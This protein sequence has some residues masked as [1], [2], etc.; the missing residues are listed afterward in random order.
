M[1]RFKA[2]KE[3]AFRIF[4][5]SSLNFFD[6]CLLQKFKELKSLHTFCIDCSKFVV[7]SKF[8][9]LYTPQNPSKIGVID[10]FICRGSSSWGFFPILYKCSHIFLNSLAY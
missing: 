2:K 9:G 10:A 8:L 5:D 3:T 6:V 7:S 1:C 4:S